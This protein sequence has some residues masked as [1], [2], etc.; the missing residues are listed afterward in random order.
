MPIFELSY[1][2]P[3]MCHFFSFGNCDARKLVEYC[4]KL[5][6]DRKYTTNLIC[7]IHSRIDRALCNL[8]T[9]LPV[10]MLGRNTTITIMQKVK[11][12]DCTNRYGSKPLLYPQT[13]AVIQLYN[14][15]CTLCTHNIKEWQQI[16][17]KKLKP[18]PLF[19]M[20]HDTHSA[21]TKKYH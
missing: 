16:D 9:K 21:Y 1:Y 15:R 14:L 3:V 11:H 5:P 17:G 8:I 7:Y 12:Y 2:D 18:L 19:V 20:V 4:N 6:R 10:H 13:P